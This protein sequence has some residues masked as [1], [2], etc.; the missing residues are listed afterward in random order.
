MKAITIWFFT[1]G[2]SG[3][4]IRVAGGVSRLDELVSKFTYRAL[5]LQAFHYER[6]ISHET[7]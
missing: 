2:G 3:G 7:I 4:D 6:I 1:G 5:F